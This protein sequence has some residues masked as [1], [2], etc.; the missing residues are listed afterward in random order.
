MKKG[1]VKPPYTPD[2]IDSL[3]PGEIFV[4]GSNLQ[5]YHG[6]GAARAAL[7]RFGAIWGNGVGLQGQSYAIPTMQ[8]GT[9]TI[10]PYVNQFIAFAKEHQEYTFLV[11]PIGCG[12]A[13]FEVE[14]IAPLFADA[15][16]VDNIVLPHSFVDCLLANV[17][18]RLPDYL[19][20]KVHGQTRTLV[21]MLIE[22]NKQNR[23]HSSE[24][25]LADL[26]KYLEHIR[27]DGDE[28]A[29]NCS[30]RSINAFASECFPNGTLDVKL[31]ESKLHHDF[32]DGIHAV[33][34][35]YVV[36]KTMTLISYLNDFRR[37][38]TPEDLKK[39][40]MEATGGVNHCGP[41]SNPYYFSFSS[42][43]I[44]R[45]FHHYI[46]KFWNELT[47]DGILDNNAFYDFMIGRH[48]RGIEK[49]GLEAVVER[50]YKSD[51]P[52][53]HEVYFPYRGGAAPVYV[54]TDFYRDVNL[55][56]SIRRFIKSCGEGKG[57]N[58]IRDY[59]EFKHILP[60]LKSDD[61]YIRFENYFIP[62][63]DD[64]LPVFSNWHGRLLFESEDVKK[65]FIKK[66]WEKMSCTGANPINL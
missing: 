18:P 9:E 17:P 30:V 32:Y 61:K 16:N 45:Y 56:I 44:S 21:D 53:H 12:I 23:Y 22:L 47:V 28:V 14:E 60:L 58:S 39:D 2:R 46:T 52:C 42:S 25:A 26:W 59:F 65:A 33:Y 20:T 37:Y 41:N 62:K 63:S 31:L 64:T 13:G 36:E 6:G 8:G 43:Y 50:N 24:E 27:T 11:T 29:F 35:D 5:G 55:D 4:F 19:Q 15:M 3:Q 1:Y 49:Y 57:P 48:N 34:E 10:Q 38:T 7:N 40:F 66:A 54:E 51:A